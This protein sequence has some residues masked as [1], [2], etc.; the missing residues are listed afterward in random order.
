MCKQTDQIRIDLERF[1]RTGELP[2]AWDPAS[3]EPEQMDELDRRVAEINAELEAIESG[4]VEPPR[5]GWL[6]QI[7][8]KP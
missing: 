1:Q 7:G 3:D 4:C 8:R 5:G 2:P 6:I